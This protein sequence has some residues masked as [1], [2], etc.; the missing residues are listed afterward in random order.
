MNEMANRRQFER[1]IARFPVKAVH[2]SM[3]NEAKSFHDADSLEQ[4]NQHSNDF[5]TGELCDLSM[6]GA[7]VRVE[8]HNFSRE[9]VVILTIDLCSES[10]ELGESVRVKTETEAEEY[11]ISCRSLILR[12]DEHYIAVAFSEIIGPTSLHHLRRTIMYNSGD[13]ERAAAEIA[14]FLT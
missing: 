6:Q 11:L 4:E 9:D 10:C 5:F 1:V 8:N 2:A 3:V 7:L 12:A 14:K 13:P